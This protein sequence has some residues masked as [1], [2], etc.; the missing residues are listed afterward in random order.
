MRGHTFFGQN[1]AGAWEDAA[2]AFHRACTLEPAHLEAH[3][4]LG[5]CHLR[6]EDPKSAIGQ[7]RAAARGGVRV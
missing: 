1:I 3:L 6:Q 4:G 7:L 2:Q 5:V